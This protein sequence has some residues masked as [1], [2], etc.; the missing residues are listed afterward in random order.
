MLS[1]ESP[2]MMSDIMSQAVV[3]F[4]T[5]FS[6]TF[7]MLYSFK[8]TFVCITGSDGVVDHPHTADA[9]KCVIGSLIVALLLI[10]VCWL[11]KASA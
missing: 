7:I 6:F 5:V 11:L 3:C 10:V 9:G 1:S 8:P 4:L 2:V